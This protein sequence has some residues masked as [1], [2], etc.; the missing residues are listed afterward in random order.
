[1]IVLP[2]G[3]RT[4]DLSRNKGSVSSNSFDMDG[5]ECE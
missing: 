5:F 4:V 3:Q 1:M 2:I